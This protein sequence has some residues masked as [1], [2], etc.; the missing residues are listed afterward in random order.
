MDL[1]LDYKWALVLEKT[2]LKFDWTFEAKKHTYVDRAFIKPDAV[3]SI[4]ISYRNLDPTTQRCRDKNYPETERVIIQQKLSD[5][6][7]LRVVINPT[8]WTII[9]FIPTSVTRYW[10]CDDVFEF[11]S[12]KD[13]VSTSHDLKLSGRSEILAHVSSLCQDSESFNLGFLF[14]IY[15]FTRLF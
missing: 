7:L 2:Y 8:T 10:N 11:S 14:H 9:T 4:L 13:S 5:R 12:E 1:S 6:K 15:F 3:E